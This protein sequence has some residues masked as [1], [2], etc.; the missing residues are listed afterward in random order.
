MFM[1]IDC[2]YFN[3]CCQ[4]TDFL[5]EVFSFEFSIRKP[6]LTQFIYVWFKQGGRG[7]FERRVSLHTIIVQDGSKQ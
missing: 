5:G 2:G 3:I 7:L 6:K 1:H 4:K